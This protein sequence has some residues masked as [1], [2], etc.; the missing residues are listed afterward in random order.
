[1]IKHFTIL[2]HLK[3]LGLKMRV[4]IPRG[5]TFLL[6]CTN[7]QQGSVWLWSLITNNGYCVLSSPMCRSPTRCLTC[8]ISNLH[9]MQGKSHHHRQ[10]NGGLVRL[11]NWL[12]YHPA[13]KANLRS[14]LREDP[15]RLLWLHLPVGYCR[16]VRCFLLRPKPAYWH[17]ES[18][19]HP[20]SLGTWA[21][22]V[23]SAPKGA[24]C[25]MQALV[26]PALPSH[27]QGQWD[28]HQP[29]GVTWRLSI[30][31]QGRSCCYAW[32]VC[33]GA[34]EMQQAAQV[35]LV[36]CLKDLSQCHV[37]QTHNT[38]IAVGR[39]LKEKGVKEAN[40]TSLLI[41]YFHVYNIRQVYVKS[42][43][44]NTTD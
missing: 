1:M 38:S 34:G 9:H 25:Q 37:L 5:K 20:S 36:S 8:I 33:A 22:L 24:P 2:F 44:T 4:Q 7:N 3:P 10:G 16:F 18:S 23:L 27:C 31:A 29:D 11:W 13:A 40:S 6:D 39:N 35:P 41:F 15:S 21:R 19:H 14:R 17:A 30:K 28:W 12:R 26:F 42:T 43:L 32:R